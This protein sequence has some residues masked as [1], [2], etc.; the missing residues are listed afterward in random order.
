MLEFFGNFFVAQIPFQLNVFGGYNNPNPN[1][2]WYKVQGIVV[3][4]R[5][6]LHRRWVCDFI[7]VYGGGGRKGVFLR[8]AIG[9]LCFLVATVVNCC[10][11]IPLTWYVTA[12][13]HATRTEGHALRE[14]WPHDVK[15]TRSEMFAHLNDVII[16]SSHL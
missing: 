9:K 7:H 14:K 15:S 12:V 6:E 2:N 13:V 10:I 1:K 5:Y 11:P 8:G 4:P 3:Y 16:S